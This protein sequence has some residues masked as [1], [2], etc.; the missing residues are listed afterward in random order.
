MPVRKITNNS[1]KS[2]Y[3]FP[4]LKMGMQVWADGPLEYD[5]IHLLEADS[6]VKSYEG[7]PLRIQYRLK[8]ERRLR[9]Y[10]PDFMVV[11]GGRIQIVEV[12]LEADAKKEERQ[13]IFRIARCACRRQGY[14]FIVVT[15]TTI[16][17]QPRL[18]NLKTFWR[19]ART[20]IDTAR[21]KHC[22]REFFRLKAEASLIE[23][24]RFFEARQLTREA[25]YSLLYWGILAT[26]LMKPVGPESIITYP[27][28]TPLTEGRRGR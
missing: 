12:K 23:I 21:Y 1:V 28:L 2:I 17:R 24:M 13:H 7:Q 16:R 4:S 27:A 20:P 15:E 10:T 19:Y 22:C 18:N 5:Y 25:A 9:T 3:L 8:G 14:E 26:D 11:R 6:E